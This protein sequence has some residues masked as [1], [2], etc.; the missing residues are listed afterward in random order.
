M[1]LLPWS[2]KVKGKAPVL[3]TVLQEW[4]TRIVKGSCNLLFGDQFSCI[5][6]EHKELHQ[7]N[8]KMEVLQYTH[9]LLIIIFSSW[10]IILAVEEIR[11]MQKSMI[12]LMCESV[13][14][15]LRWGT[16]ISSPET[17]CWERWGFPSGSS[18]SPTLSSYKKICRYPRR[19]SRTSCV[20]I[21]TYVIKYTFVSSH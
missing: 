7:I 6:Q 14:G 11:S 15:H 8:L 10:E 21:H 12:F 2:S 9:P 13:C 18:T 17:Q 20:Q 1:H 19:Y 4:R 5:V 3:W 16:L